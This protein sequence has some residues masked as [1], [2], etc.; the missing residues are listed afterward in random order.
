LLQ[1]LLKEDEVEKSKSKVGRN[2]KLV[3]S[4]SDK[5][6]IPA[7]GG[8]KRGGVGYGRK[9]ERMFR[10]RADYRKHSGLTTEGTE[11]RVERKEK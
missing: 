10:S 2:L 4:Q 5:H 7:Q 3:S 11:R 8:R 9:Q 1:K 6:G